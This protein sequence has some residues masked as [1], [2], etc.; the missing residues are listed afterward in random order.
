[1]GLYS[2]SDNH[3]RLSFEVLVLAHQKD[4]TASLPVDYQLPDRQEAACD[5][6]EIHVQYMHA[7][8]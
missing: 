3:Q 4:I 2:S 6:W 7:Q 5:P 8:H 1:M